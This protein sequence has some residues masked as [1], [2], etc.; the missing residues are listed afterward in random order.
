MCGI[1][2]Y[3][4]LEDTVNFLVNALEK[5]E[6]RGYDSAGIAVC[7]DEEIYCLKKKGRINV[8]KDEIDFHK[9]FNGS[10]G[11]GHTRWATHGEPS[12]VNAHPHIC[13]SG[14]IAIVHN[15][16]IEN[17]MS[18]KLDLKKNGYKFKSET[19]TEVAAALID[20]VYEGN[21]FEAVKKTVKMLKGSFA[22][23]ILCRDFPNQIIAVKK[24]SPLVLGFGKN[25]SYIASDISAFVDKT[26]DI[27]RLNECEIAI[28]KSN[29]VEYF[30]FEG[31]RIEKSVT[32]VDWSIGT[33]SKEG[34]E[35]Y[36]IKEIM[37]QP[38]AFKSTMES[39]IKDNKIF[40]NELKD[41]DEDY[42]KKIDKIYMVACG[43]S[44]HVCVTA[45]YIFEKIAKVSVEV[46]LASE[47]RYRTPIIGKNTLVILVSQSGETADSLAAL[48]ESKRNGAKVLAIVNVVGSSI[49]TEADFILY[50]WAGMEIAV[51]TTK[52][53]SAQLCCVYML[54][55]FFAKIKNL[56]ED[57][58]YGNYITYL[59]RMPELISK[60]LDNKNEIFRISKKYYQYE[61]VFF[62][63]RGIDYA[64]SMEGSL[65]FKE[66]SYVNCEAYAAG[67]LKHGPISLIEDKTLIFVVAADQNLVRK[68]VSNIKEVKARGAICVIITTENSIIKTLNVADEIIYIPD[69]PNFML[70]SLTVIPLQ[71]ISYYNALLRERD[72]DK[73]RNLAKSVTVE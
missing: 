46:D 24:E 36:M 71:L 13:G 43:S 56:I 40:F 72:I 2:G 27:C 54:S 51:A 38:K 17:Y 39:R 8:L 10:A 60:V 15:G 61:N 66:V 53:Y 25:E 49:A 14:K 42:I 48:R 63:G 70:P 62:M 20:F 22:L 45:K 50:T 28:L 1:V 30:D 64:A 35:H 57:D 26:K 58:L 69:A 33:N 37:E 52:A 29:S 21:I 67:E 6:Y 7:D 5:L 73:P 65:K 12:D 11:I 4:G 32:T 68:T 47:F 55:L 18:L 16:I 34:F 19:D 41:F 23:G 44:Y 3:V 9:N 59:N 31:H